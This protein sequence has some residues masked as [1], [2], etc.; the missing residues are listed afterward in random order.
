MFGKHL[1][2][3]NI[4]VRFDATR[5]VPDDVCQAIGAKRAKKGWPYFEKDGKRF[6]VQFGWNEF[7]GRLYDGKSFEIVLAQVGH[8][9]TYWVSDYAKPVKSAVREGDIDLDEGGF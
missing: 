7:H 8:R 9:D 4:P 2:L 5:P 6:Y 3:E 1:R